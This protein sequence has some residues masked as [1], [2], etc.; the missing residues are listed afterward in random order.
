MKRG[1]PTVLCRKVLISEG[2]RFERVGVKLRFDAC[3]RLMSRGI[4]GRKFLDQGHCTS[5]PSKKGEATPR[6][7]QRGWPR[8]TNFE[9][10]SFDDVNLLGWQ[11]LT[12]GVEN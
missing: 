10:V 6:Q 9:L 1:V 11:S 7:L 4:N 12:C 5:S 2:R 8:S 3:R